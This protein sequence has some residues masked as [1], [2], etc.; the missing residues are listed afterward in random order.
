MSKILVIDDREG[1]CRML[2]R[3]LEEKRHDVLEALSA[4]SGLRLAVETM[5]DL[6]V[7]DWNLD[8]GITGDSVVRSL[9]SDPRL[10]GVPVIMVSGIS[11]TPETEAAAL[12]AGADLFLLK[13]E[14]WSKERPRPIFR[15]VDAL[16]IKRRLSPGRIVL[17]EDDPEASDMLAGF[18]TR[19]GHVVSPA[20]SGKAGLEI[21]RG[22]DPDLVILDLSLP[23]M[24]GLEICTQLKRETRTRDIPILI[25]SA[26]AS[27]Q[28]QLLALEYHADHYLTKPV[29]DYEE[30]YGWV[31]ALLRRKP[32]LHASK[33]VIRMGAQGK[34]DVANHIVVLGEKS[35][36]DL[37]AKLFRLLCEL[38]SH[39]DETLSPQYLVDRIWN[40][41]GA[42]HPR[43]KGRQPTEITTRPALR[44]CDRNHPGAR[45]SSR[46]LQAAS[47][48]TRFPLEK[49][50]ACGSSPES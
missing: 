13:D 43:Q 24:D 34:I 42:A 26:R 49:R 10:K 4:E 39:P 27:T 3:I 1:E 14:F 7:L 25:L 18:L 31:E 48:T 30:F 22:L 29:E 23:D 16:L 40:N 46:M 5:P 47:G 12:Q 20:Y 2:R 6:I 9:R 21:V 41:E 19:K 15:H 37:P 11:T 28:A 38:A 8:S 50:G 33:N 36:S 45:L 44:R 32:Q 17:V 35:I